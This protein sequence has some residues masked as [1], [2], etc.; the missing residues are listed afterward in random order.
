VPHQ[1]GRA[2]GHDTAL[3]FCHLLP[4]RMRDLY[5]AAF[6]RAKDQENNL[7]WSPSR[8]LASTGGFERVSRFMQF[9]HYDDYRASRRV[10][11]PRRGFG[12]HCLDLYLGLASRLG[13][14]SLYA[15]PNL[16]STFRRRT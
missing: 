9:A 5:A 11:G 14:Y 13:S 7:F 6:G 2:G 15:L 8:L 12:G 4:L 10:R 3:P 16:A 1:Q